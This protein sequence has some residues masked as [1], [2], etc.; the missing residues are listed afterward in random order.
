[1]PFFSIVIP[2]YN[3]G[4]YLVDCLDS[5]A[6]QSFNDFEVILVDDGSSDNS[7]EICESFMSKDSRFVLHTS[8]HSGVSHAR[9]T[10][11]ELAKGQYIAFVDA[12]DLMLPNALTLYYDCISES[13]AQ[14]IKCGFIERNI[15]TH[16]DII[17]KAKNPQ[18]ING[19]ETD[20]ILDATEETGYHGFLWNSVF[21]ATIAKQVK[22][23][24]TISF[25]E[26][27]IYSRTCFRLCNSLYISDCITYCYFKR[28]HSSLSTVRDNYMFAS[29][30]IKEYLSRLALV[31]S[32]RRAAYGKK[33]RLLYGR[34]CI[35][36][37]NEFKRTKRVSGAL[38]LY[39]F[40]RS[41]IKT[42]QGGHALL[43]KTMLE[44]ILK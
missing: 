20:R 14:I 42:I 29:S 21:S 22:F 19:G 12:D 7:K 31:S 6:T 39:S 15:T 41:E 24:E 40:I 35:A 9:N 38:K 13:G 36:I 37:R 30:A 10:G 2:V 8:N 43:L 28:G 1:M 18:C 3:V 27:H 33:E 4:Q 26:D 16:Q 34:L 5:I 11:I 44:L 32:G 23:D 25:L 17:Y